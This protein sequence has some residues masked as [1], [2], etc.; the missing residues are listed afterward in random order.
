[1]DG[2]DDCGNEMMWKSGINGD[3]RLA[4][5]V[6]NYRLNDTVI[7]LR[8]S[9]EIFLGLNKQRETYVLERS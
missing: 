9:E 1:M 5:R 6:E 8:S 2:F 3:K 7:F 4:I